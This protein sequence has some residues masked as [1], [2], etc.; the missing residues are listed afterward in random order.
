LA[1]NK[2]S[3]SK[4]GKKTLLSPQQE[5]ELSKRIIRLGQTGRP[6]TFKILRTRVFTYCEQNNIT[7]PFVKEKEMAGRDWVERF[8]RRNP[9][10]ASHKV[11]NLRPKRA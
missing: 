10:I 1:E 8:L 2:Q 7:N 9:M 4:L 6:I 3:K 11:Q 5:K